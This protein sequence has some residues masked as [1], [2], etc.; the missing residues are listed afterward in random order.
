M[1]KFYD[2]V[3]RCE[4][5]VLPSNVGSYTCSNREENPNLSKLV[6]FVVIVE[7]EEDWPRLNQGVE[8]RRILG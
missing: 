1:R 6:R 2:W 5:M 7:R 4:L 8:W 3:N